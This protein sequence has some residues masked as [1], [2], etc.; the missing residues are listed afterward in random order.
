MGA[1]LIRARAAR[2]AVMARLVPDCRRCG[3][4]GSAHVREK[5]CPG[6]LIRGGN[7]FSD[8]DMRPRTSA[9][10]GKVETGFPIRTCAHGLSRAVEGM[11]WHQGTDPAGN[12]RKANHPA[13]SRYQHRPRARAC[14]LRRAGATLAPPALG[15]ALFLAQRNESSPP[16][17]RYAATC[18]SFAPGRRSSATRRPFG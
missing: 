7:R 15:G 10:P 14:H 6:Q 12:C 2:H 13:A 5:A 9:C 11:R 16:P 3:K 1:D 17:I 4:I 8:K 18:C